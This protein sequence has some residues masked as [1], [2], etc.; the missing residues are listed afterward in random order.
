[1]VLTAGQIEVAVLLVQG[2][3]VEQHGAGHNQGDPDTGGEDLDIV[4]GW[5]ALDIVVLG[6]PLK[7]AAL[8]WVSSKT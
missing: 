4:V 3:E 5:D 6:E 2:E 7:N 8:I 1:M